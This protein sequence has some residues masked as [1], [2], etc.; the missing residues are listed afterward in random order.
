MQNVQTRIKRRDDMMLTADCNIYL[1]NTLLDCQFDI[2][3]Q[4]NFDPVDPIT[5]TSI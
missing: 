4:A 3:L 5:S 2:Q 1:F